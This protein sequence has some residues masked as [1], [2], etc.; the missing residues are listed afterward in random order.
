MQALHGPRGAGLELD[1]DNPATG[2][3]HEVDLSGTSAF[4]LPVEQMRTV[5]ARL[6]G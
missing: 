4:T 2:L 1:R 6:T 3:D 5:T